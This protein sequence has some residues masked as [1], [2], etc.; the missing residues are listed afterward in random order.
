MKMMFLAGGEA[1]VYVYVTPPHIRALTTPPQHKTTKTC[2]KSAN[3]RL[4]LMETVLSYTLA[5]CTSSD[6]GVHYLHCRPTP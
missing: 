1:R 3:E 6:T 2:I 5:L 4:L